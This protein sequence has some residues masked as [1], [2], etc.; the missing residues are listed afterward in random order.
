MNQKIIITGLLFGFVFLFGFWLSRVGKPY[1][2]ILFNFH[3]LIGLAMGVYLILTVYQAHRADPFGALDFFVLAL[4]GII[5][6]GLVAAGGLLSVQAAGGLGNINPAM[7]TAITVVHKVFPY[8]A[9]LST[10]ATLYLLLF[11]KG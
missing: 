6:I 7:L 11:R 2:A 4:T 5:F 3:K 8:F 1:N 10:A 9:V